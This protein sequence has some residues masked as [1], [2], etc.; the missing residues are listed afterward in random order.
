MIFR[1]LFDTKSSTYTYLLGCEETREAILIDSV[2]TQ[3]E[4]DLKLLK[5]LNLKLVFTIE[6]HI[7]ADHITGG[8]VIR[9]NFSSVKT[10]VG[11]NSGAN[12]DDLIFVKDGDHIKFGKESLQVLET[13]GRILIILKF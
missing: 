8:N 3:V 6:T 13:P 11:H 5:D 7:H 2:D 4:R 12:F 10:I 1:Q 9:K